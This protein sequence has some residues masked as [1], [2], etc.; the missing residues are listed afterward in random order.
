MASSIESSRRA[1]DLCFGVEPAQLSNLDQL[2]G[3]SRGSSQAH[4]TFSM[5]VVVTCVLEKD[6]EDEEKGYK[7]KEPIASE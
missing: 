3:K 5:Y 6:D 2:S 4:R 7:K 1:K